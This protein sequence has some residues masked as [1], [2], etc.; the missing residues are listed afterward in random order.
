M[1]NFVAAIKY[2]RF[3]TKNPYRYSGIMLWNSDKI[4]CIYNTYIKMGLLV[5]QHST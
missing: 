3:A 1:E 4:K 5:E 2:G